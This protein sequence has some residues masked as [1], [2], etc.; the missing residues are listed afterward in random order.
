LSIVSVMS[1][2]TT[3]PVKKIMSA[4]EEQHLPA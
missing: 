3:L 2:K 1:Q 4:L